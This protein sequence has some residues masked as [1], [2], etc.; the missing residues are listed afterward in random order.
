MKNVNASNSLLDVPREY[1]LLQANCQHF[2]LELI[3]RI[4]V[5]DEGDVYEELEKASRLPRTWCRF[6]LSMLGV[7]VNS[8][9]VYWPLEPMTCTVVYMYHLC[10]SLVMT[11]DYTMRK[12]RVELEYNERRF[13]HRSHTHRQKEV[14]KKTAMSN[15]KVLAMLSLCMASPLSYG[16]LRLFSSYGVWT[17]G[18]V[19]IM[20]PCYYAYVFVAARIL[21]DQIKCS[22]AITSMRD[23]NR[24]ARV[25]E[26]YDTLNRRW[27]AN[28]IQPPCPEAIWWQ[29]EP[30]DRRCR[31][32]FLDKARGEQVYDDDTSFGPLDFE[33]AVARWESKHQRPI[34]IRRSYVTMRMSI[35][36]AVVVILCMLSGCTY[37]LYVNMQSSR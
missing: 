16:T 14:G 25:E 3:R 1:S 29:S 21:L 32:C 10:F 23:R 26:A 24:E 6:L 17:V 20:V 30:C 13:L 19:L 7:L 12:L 18:I 28:E 5:F 35:F 36:Y 22:N 2:I 15:D 8:V 34:D 11:Q 9:F 27:N 33:A 31:K 4:G 37:A